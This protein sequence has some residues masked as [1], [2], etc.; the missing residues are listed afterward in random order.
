MSNLSRRTFLKQNAILGLGAAL[1]PALPSIA[2]PSVSTPAILGGTPLFKTE[3]PKW[4]RWNP[5]TDEPRLLEVLRSGIWSR[6]DVTAE[7]EQQWANALGMK[8]SL[9]VVNGTSALTIALNQLDI[10]AGDEFSV[11]E[12]KQSNY[13]QLVWA[14][15]AAFGLVISII[16]LTR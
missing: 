12:K 2:F 3:W 4:P 15:S 9:L 13:L 10:R 1:S 5:E 14:G 7:F 6:A 8:R 11:K 16:N